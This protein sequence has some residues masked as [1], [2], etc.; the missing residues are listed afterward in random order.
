MLPSIHYMLPQRLDKELFLKRIT[1]QPD[2]EINAELCS[3]A[4]RTP[5]SGGLLFFRSPVPGEDCS[6]IT[7]RPLATHAWKHHLEAIYNQLPVICEWNHCFYYIKV[8]LHVRHYFSF[9]IFW[10]LS[11]LKAFYL[12]P[13]LV[14]LSLG[15]HNKLGYDGILA[16]ITLH[17]YIVS[18]AEKR[19]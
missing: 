13:Y 8:I 1:L 4:A 12:C 2:S 16:T 6:W 11:S 17:S 7:A 3:T 19:Q 15:N 18:K 5:P 10:Y 9:F 14:A